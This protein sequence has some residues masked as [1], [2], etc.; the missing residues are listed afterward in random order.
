MIFRKVIDIKPA[1]Q[2]YDHQSHFMLWGSCFADRLTDYLR[3]ELYPVAVSPY[4]IMYN[5]ISIAEGMERLLA[6]ATPTVDELVEWDGRWHSMMHHGAF[7]HPSREMALRRMVDAFHT[8]ERELPETD[9]FVFTLGTAWIYEEAGR[10]VNNCHKLPASRFTRRRLSVK[11]IVER[12]A[13]LLKR[14]LERCPSA[15]VLLTVSPIPHYRDG[16][17]ESRLSKAVLLL[18]AEEL[19][20]HLPERVHYFPSYEIMQDEL[21]DYRFYGEDMTHPSD[22]AVAYIM[23][24]FGETFLLREE[25]PLLS[26][27]HKIRR[28][29]H[30][31]PLSD[32]PDRLREYYSHL[33]DSLRQINTQLPREI[34]ADEID[35]I[36]QILSSL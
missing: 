30:H 19:L 16:A 36:T 28:Q 25:M 11:E 2:Q 10:V 1:P 31:R 4:G 34:L 22:Q 35:R 14:L 3:E 15:R 32:D 20:R 6:G 9:L 17:H 27:W 21:R 24:R 23:E 7:S 33:L 12:W 8:A 18:A 29:L 26:S 5:P 13:P